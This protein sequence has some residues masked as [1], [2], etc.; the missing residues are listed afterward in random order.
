MN[1][2]FKTRPLFFQY[3]AL[4]FTAAF[5]P[6]IIASVSLFIS[7][8]TLHE[9]II[10]SNQASVTLIQ[11]SLDSKII[12]LQNTLY[13]IDQ[14]P[15]LTRYALQNNPRSAISTLNKYTQ[16]H[17]SMSNVLIFVNDTAYFYSSGGTFS[18]SDL[19]HQSFIKDLLSHNFSID[20]WTNTLYSI[21]SPTFWPVNSANQ[22]PTYLY[23][24]SPV[25]SN[26][27]FTNTNVPRTVVLLIKQ[28]FIRDI[29]KSSQTNIGESVLLFDS[30]MDLISQL[31]TN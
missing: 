20:E 6:V 18:I 23:L 13:L 16:H 24:F 26:F 22:M 5:L 8:K 29:F 4:F 1:K 10:C 19:N 15:T 25:Y 2:R 31:T 30:N 21:T 7:N 17:D 14:D 11:Q 12:E 28:E 3:L 27:Q 9:E